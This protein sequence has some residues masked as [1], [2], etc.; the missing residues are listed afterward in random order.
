MKSG[1]LLS[2]PGPLALRRSLAKVLAAGAD[3]GCSSPLRSV[4]LLR[5]AGFGSLINLFADELMAAVLLR[6]PVVRCTPDGIHDV[7][8]ANF[9]TRL[10]I[11]SCGRCDAAPF[12]HSG[13]W[14]SEPWY[15]AASL[16]SER[17]PR[18]QVEQTK[19]FLY[20]SL[21]TFKHELVV[22]ARVVSSQLSLGSQPY[23]GVHIRRGDKHL[24]SAPVPVRAFATEVRRLINRGKVFLAS[25]SPQTRGKLQRML[26]TGFDV[27]EQRRLPQVAYSARGVRGPVRDDAGAFSR[28]EVEAHFFVDVL[29]LARAA[30]FVGTASSNVGRVVHFL[31]PMDAMSVSL[32]FGGDFLGWKQQGSD[33]LALRRGQL[34]NG[35]VTLLQTPGR[36][37]SS[38]QGAQR[39]P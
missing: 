5:D 13:N 39:A 35:T 33:F 36:N 21:F 19:R 6:V 4:A 32:D 27:V 29:L 34:S 1:G 3:R 22:A 15:V 28:K 2:R 14:T 30:V 26:G 11:A 20:R 25:D 38:V 10:T 18:Q 17:W 16:I 37:R 7:W 9:E 31:R 8:G 23:V 12:R 24:E